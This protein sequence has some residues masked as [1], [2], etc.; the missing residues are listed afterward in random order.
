MQ[1]EELPGDGFRAADD[2]VDRMGAEINRGNG[3]D[4]IC[5][6][7]SFASKATPER[8]KSGFAE[9]ECGGVVPAYEN[10]AIGGDFPR[11][12]RGQIGCT[13]LLILLGRAKVGKEHIEIQRARDFS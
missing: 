5:G 4:R 11:A 8:A 2:K 3:L 7:L 13:I 1:I 10:G 9:F 6:N 12:A